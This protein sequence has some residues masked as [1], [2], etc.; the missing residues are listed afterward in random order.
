MLR[1]LKA[2]LK[3]ASNAQIIKGVF[4][5]AFRKTTFKGL[6]VR[7]PLDKRKLRQFKKDAFNKMPL[8]KRCVVVSPPVD[9]SKKKKD[10][11]SLAVGSLG[12]F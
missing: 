10:D 9:L 11:C 6:F 5:L 7:M 2:F 4:I 8:I 1:Q 3:N 12:M